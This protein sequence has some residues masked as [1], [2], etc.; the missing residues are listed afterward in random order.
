MFSLISIIQ[1]TCIHCSDFVHK[2]PLYVWS[3]LVRFICFYRVKE[4]VIVSIC[5]WSLIPNYH[6]Y[7]EVGQ[8]AVD[9]M[10]PD[11]WHNFC[12][13][14]SPFPSGSVNGSGGRGGIVMW[15]GVGI[16]VR[17][18]ELGVSS[19][20]ALCCHLWLLNTQVQPLSYF[21]LYFTALVPIHTNSD[22][23]SHHPAYHTT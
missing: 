16:G 1:G 5:L 22:V 11:W 12:L 17:W 8:S 10:V 21:G 14:L 23:P 9:H 15:H 20:F 7:L 6:R 13:F 2:A 18:C 3:N 4:H 19:K